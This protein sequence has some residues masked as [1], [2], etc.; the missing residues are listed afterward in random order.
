[1]KGKKELKTPNARRQRRIKGLV[2]IAAGAA[3][4]TAGGTWALWSASTTVGGGTITA[5]NLDISS[6]HHAYFYDI[7][8]GGTVD[9]GGNYTP[10]QPAPSTPENSGRTDQT[11]PVKFLLANSE[12]SLAGK[13]LSCG[14]SDSNVDPSVD[15]TNYLAHSIPNID[16]WNMVPGDR[17]LAVWPLEVALDGDNMVAE[18]K[19]NG[20]PN[21]S[22][23]ALTDPVFWLL[24]DGT[25]V[26]VDTTGQPVALLQA[27][28]G[29]GPDARYDYVYPSGELIPVIDRAALTGTDFNVCFIMSV[30]FDGNHQDRDY[31]QSVLLDLDQV[32][33]SLEQTREPFVGNFR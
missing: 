29:S 15:P 28:K 4:L 5:G 3:I 17:V 14:G 30:T 23:P 16:E 32:V 13:R 2:A 25:P 20:L 7:S 10:S 26:P 31:A 33:A 1:M 27:G 18:L 8:T 21:L 9:A 24:I 12:P 19:L 11:E 6:A 22:D